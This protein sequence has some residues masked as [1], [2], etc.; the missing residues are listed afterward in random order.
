MT[1]KIAVSSR[2]LFNIEDGDAIWREKGQEAFDKYMRDNAGKPL[3][4]GVAFNL[5]R[6]LLALNK[7][8][9][10]KKRVEVVLLSRNS[11]DASRRVMHSVEHYDL[12]IETGVFCCGADRFRF[13][14]SIGADLFLSANSDDVIAA[15]RH[16]VAA[17]TMLPV[18]DDNAFSDV[19]PDSSKV[20]TIALDGDA[21]IFNGES[22]EKYRA[23]G[24]AAYLDHERANR[25][26][27]LGDGPFKSFFLKVIKLQQELPNGGEGAL[28]IAL[29]TARGIQSHFRVM[30]TLNNWGV[31][32]SQ[33]I[34][35]GGAPK[36]PM[37]NALGA[38]IFFD[39]TKSNIDS[40]LNHSIAAACHVPNGEGGIKDAAL[41][42]QQGK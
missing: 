31:R 17:A 41:L 26:V 1:L 5:V 24:M 39:D 15:L 10:T 32:L 3:R 35:C 6:K 36:G 25:D 37:L 29:V 28:R 16:G 33:A 2:S 34:F 38:D 11:A 21:V 4:P 12:D 20:V 27:P 42:A 14:S 19:G 40:A 30:E 8:D 7:I 23:H 9:P 18:N 13:A 22:D